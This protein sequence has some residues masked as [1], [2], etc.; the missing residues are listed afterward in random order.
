MTCP[1]CVKNVS[2]ALQAQPGVVNAEV[3]LEDGQ[4]VVT[5]STDQEALVNAVV[6]A[7]Y[8]V[9]SVSG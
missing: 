1:H 2:K 6:E 7:G 9:E 8:S 5:G 3:S 4:A